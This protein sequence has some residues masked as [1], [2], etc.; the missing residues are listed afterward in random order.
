VTRQRRLSVPSSSGPDAVDPN[1]VASYLDNELDPDAVAEYEKKCLTSDVT[2]AEVASVHQILSLLGQKVKVP[3]A[4]RSRMYQLVKGREASRARKTQARRSD[5]IEPLTTPIQPWVLPEAPRR[6]WIQRFG[7]AVVCLLLIGLSSLSAWWSLTAPPPVAFW[8]LPIHLVN[9]KPA[10]PPGPTSAKDEPEAHAALE[11][12]ADTHTGK[13]AGN[14]PQVPQPAPAAD[15]VNQP[16]KSDAEGSKTAQASEAAAKSKAALSAPAP[17]AGAIGSA[18]AA[19]ADGILLRYNPDQRLWERLK[20]QT[21]LFPS[22]RLLC[23]APFRATLALGKAQIVLPGE[24]EIRILPQSTAALPALELLQGRLNLPPQPRGS[25]LV[26]F[27]DRAVNI[28]TSE[29]SATALERSARLDYGRII[30]RA[31]ALLIYCTK[32]EATVSVDKKRELLP[33]LDVLALDA[34]GTKRNTLEALPSWTE[35]GEPSPRE[36]QIR[37]Q[38]ARAFHPNRPILADIV[39]ASEDDNPE[40]KRL[41]TVALKSLGEMSLLFP[42]LSRKDDP[43]ARRSALAAI[44]GYMAQGSEA[45]SRVRDQLVEEFGEET[46]AFVAKM[47]VGFS[48]DEASSPQTFEQLVG[49]LGP[50]QESVGVR[51]LALESL[52]RLTGRDDLGYDPDHPEGRGLGAWKDLQRQGK[53]RFSAPRSKAS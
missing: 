46:A 14:V 33:A 29:A 43:V 4:A 10:V 20:G 27:A 8:A 24:S 44:R 48:P 28:E 42:M 36:L 13:G 31:P 17:P 5:V 34:A 11:A 19:A 35:G 52:K 2:L 3:A 38:F 39:V 32:G 16:S 37:D 53:L 1:I 7:P 41:S 23:L 9:E 22:N 30:T 25:V 15:V 21:P 40:I 51:E 26:S 49:L 6:S 50:G 47:L 18:A 12:A 45:A